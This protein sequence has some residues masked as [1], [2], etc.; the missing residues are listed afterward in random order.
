MKLP[1]AYYGDP[2]LRKKGVRVEEINDE[3]RKLVE[4]MIQTMREGN[5]IG[6]AAQQVHLA[7]NLFITE[8][9]IPVPIGDDKVRWDPGKLRVFI[10]PKILQHSDQQWTQEEGCLSIPKLYRPVTRPIAIIVEAT[11]LDGNVFKEEFTW[12]EARTIMHE[13]D[14]INGVLFIDRLQGKMRRELEPLLHDLK[15]KHSKDK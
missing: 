11:D 4:D 8:A 1:L 5:G 7:L 9:P 14:H 15:K 6:L 3:I 12:L 10:N 2:I 13:N